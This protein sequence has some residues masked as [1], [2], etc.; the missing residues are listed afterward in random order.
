MRCSRQSSSRSITRFTGPTPFFSYRNGTDTEY[1]SA[2]VPFLSAQEKVFDFYIGMMILVFPGNSVSMN[3]DTS[4][5][6]PMGTG[7]AR[8]TLITCTGFPI[9]Y[10]DIMHRAKTLT[11]PAPGTGLYIHA[12]GKAP[13]SHV[14]DKLHGHKR[15]RQRALYFVRIDRSGPYGCSNRY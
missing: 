15:S 13:F 8:Y 11:Y 10:S 1:D 14:P 6:T 12:D 3:Q 5:W 2:S 7:H 9:L 4:R